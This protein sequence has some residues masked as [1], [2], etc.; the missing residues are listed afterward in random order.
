MSDPAR[1]GASRDPEALAFLLSA[2]QPLEPLLEAADALRREGHGDRVSYSPKAFL[3]LTQLCRDNCG[4][5]TFAKPPT[6]GARAYMTEEEVLALARAA[7]QAGCAEALFTLGDK[8]ERR[9]RSARDELAQMGFATTI[10]YLAHIAGRVL[11]ETGLIP[12]LNPGVMT[13]EEMAALRRVGASQGLMLE[14]ASPRLLE[15]GQA[16]WASPDKRPASRLAT[17]RLA[18]ELDVPFTT[19]LLIGIGAR[20]WTSG[21]PPSP[22]WPRRR[23]RCMSRS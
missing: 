14:Q 15:R 12:H 5:C 11:E 4:Y 20:L 16:H 19:G 17:L 7:A 18:G 22:C 13:R 6:P 23:G 8:P 1:L 9:Y 21:P 3:P 2:R 10:D